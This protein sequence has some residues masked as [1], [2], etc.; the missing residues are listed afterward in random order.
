M[1]CLQWAG[2]HAKRFTRFVLINPHSNPLRCIYYYLH[3]PRGNWGSERLKS[4]RL[5][6]AEPGYETVL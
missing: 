1:V 6:V 5:K 2:F 3:F 4:H